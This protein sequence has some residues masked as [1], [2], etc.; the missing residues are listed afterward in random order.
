MKKLKTKNQKFLFIGILIVLTG[1]LSCS[2]LEDKMLSESSGSKTIS[3]RIKNDAIDL[4]EYYSDLFSPTRDIIKMKNAGIELPR[5]E[6]GIQAMAFPG[7]GGGTCNGISIFGTYCGPGCT[8]IPYILDP[9]GNKINAMAQ[10][11]A[12]ERNL[13]YVYYPANKNPNSPITVLIHGGA[14]FQ[15]PDPGVVNGWITKF[16]PVNDTQNLVKNLLDS[17]FVVV[18]VLYRLAKY[19]TLAVGN[20]VSVQDQINDI[21]AAIWHIKS[22]FLTCLVLKANSIQVLGE[23]AGGHLALMWAY[24]GTHSSISYIKSVIS[25]YAPTNLNQFGRFLKDERPTSPS[26]SCGGNYRL[27]NPY[28]NPPPTTDLPFHFFFDIDDYSKV[29]ASVLPFNCTISTQTTYIPW[30]LYP[31]Y[32]PVT[33]SPTVNYRIIDLYRM[34]ESGVKQPVPIPYSSSLLSAISP[35][36]AANT[37]KNIPTFIMHGKVDWLV[38]YNKCA[39]GMKNKLNNLGGID[40]LPNTTSTLPS[41]YPTTYKHYMKMYDNANHTMDGADLLQV[42]KDIVKWFYGHK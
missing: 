9:F 5:T 6:T 40:S 21:D 20:D 34:L 41:T 30:P 35:K 16:A 39:D 19:D 10:Y 1:L 36:D 2:K 12:D 14:W 25:M 17:G 24:T 29:S 26:F 22:N 4:V 32:F 42:R 15:G 31:F 8:P 28:W 27:G 18:S 23:S 33:T 37:G 7:G 13:Y 3:A 11:G 38:P